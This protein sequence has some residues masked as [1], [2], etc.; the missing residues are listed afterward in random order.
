MLGIGSDNGFALF[1]IF[2]LLIRIAF[3]GHGLGA[4]FLLG[5]IGSRTQSTP[6]AWYSY[7]ST[8]SAKP[9]SSAVKGAP[10]ASSPVRRMSR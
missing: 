5:R 7:T 1:I 10:C 2:E 6:A 9:D 3:I 8:C 4:L